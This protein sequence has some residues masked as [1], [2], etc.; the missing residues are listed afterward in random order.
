MKK[1]L[2]VEDDRDLAQITADMLE[3]YQYQVTIVT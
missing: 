1:I 2:I 3:A